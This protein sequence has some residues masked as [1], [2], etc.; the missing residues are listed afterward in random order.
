MIDFFLYNTFYKLLISYT[1]IQPKEGIM[2][3]KVLKIN[4]KLTF[5]EN[6]MSYIFLIYLQKH[7]I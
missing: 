2:Q 1:K 4:K 6:V 5:V 3:Y 7:Q